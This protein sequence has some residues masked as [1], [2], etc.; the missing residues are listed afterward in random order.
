MASRASSLQLGTAS[1]RVTGMSSGNLWEVRCLIAGNT[2]TIL[3]LYWDVSWH[4]SI[5]RDTFF[6]PAHVAIYVGA[7]LGGLGAAAAILPTTFGRGPVAEV[8]R[9]ASVRVWGFH[10]PLGAFVCAWGGIAML[11]SAPFD[12]WWHSA[13]GLDVKILS[14]PHVLLLT[15]MLAVGF[16]TLLMILPLRAHRLRGPLDWLLFYAGG[17]VLSNVM[18]ALDEF[19][20]RSSMHSARPY[21]V[22]SARRP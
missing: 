22:F 16:G 18:I 10:G 19:A 15:G 21:W 4:M 20:W 8:R 13:Y 6:T 3:G 2:S 5:G 11:S 7:I 17:V 9:Q 14:P 1:G 12:N